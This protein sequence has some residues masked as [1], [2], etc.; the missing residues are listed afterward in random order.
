[1]AIYKINTTSVPGTGAVNTIISQDVTM[2]AETLELLTG[3][4]FDVDGTTPV[5]GA[6]V[7]LYKTL[8]ATS[9]TVTQEAIA[10]TDANG[11]YG[12][13]YDFDTVTYS[14]SLKIYTPNTTA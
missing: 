14:Y 1:M 7:I 3:Q 2:A 13:P 5:V 11:D 4:V 10:Y 6:A 9:N 12:F 8:V